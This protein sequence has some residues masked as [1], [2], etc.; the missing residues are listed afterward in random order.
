MGGCRNK[1]DSIPRSG[2][3]DFLRVTLLWSIPRRPVW[4]RR[5]MAAMA[6]LTACHSVP[7]PPANFSDP[8]WRLREG[9]AVWQSGRAAPEIAGEMQLATRTEGGVWLQFT[10]SPFPFVVAQATTTNW[11]VQFVPM[12]RTYS[13]PGQPPGRIAWLQLARVFTT[14]APAKGWVWEWQQAG[15][16]RLVNPKSGE[17]IEGFF[18]NA[19]LGQHIVRAG[20]T[21]T[22]IA[23]TYRVT[24][25]A[26][27]AANLDK[28]DGQRRFRVGETLLIP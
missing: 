17:R 25:A 24:L 23:Q 18:N 1:L 9:Q 15:A 10:K 5:C 6:L 3:A 13:G 22:K 8:A 19:E 4:P 12:N 20:E 2:E 11:L 14:G 16:W 26:L 21:P 7:L 27:V 28:L